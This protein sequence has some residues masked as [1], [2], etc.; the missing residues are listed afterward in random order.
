MHTHHFS[1]PSAICS[2]SL[3]LAACGRNSGSGPSTAMID[4]MKKETVGTYRAHYEGAP[5]SPAYAAWKLRMNE[6]QTFEMISAP[7]DQFANWATSNDSTLAIKGTWTI[8]DESG[9]LAALLTAQEVNGRKLN[10]TLTVRLGDR[11]LYVTV[12]K[13]S[14]NTVEFKQQNAR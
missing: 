4:A 2:L 9:T 7:T 13:S 10:D 12:H 8:A 3:L 6:N 14:P 11:A 1:R 5:P